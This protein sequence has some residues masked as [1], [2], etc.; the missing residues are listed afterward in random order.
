ME[1]NIIEH[2]Y[3]LLCVSYRTIN[4]TKNNTKIAHTSTAVEVLLV[5]ILF[6]NLKW[7]ILCINIYKCFG[8]LYFLVFSFG[9]AII[10]IH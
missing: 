8:M 5:L 4:S 6:V 3:A 10:C 1:Y 2:N 9:I 7:N